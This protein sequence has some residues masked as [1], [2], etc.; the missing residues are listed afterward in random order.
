MLRRASAVVLSLSKAEFEVETCFLVSIIRITHILDISILISV[1]LFY[2]FFCY[3]LDSL[4]I[5]Y[6][7][8]ISG[9]QMFQL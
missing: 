9:V 4:F 5:C 3:W 7:T 8:K 1:F 6:S 2:Y